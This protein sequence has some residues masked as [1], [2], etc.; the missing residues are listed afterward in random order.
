MRFPTG[1]WTG[2]WQGDLERTAARRRAVI[3]GFVAALHDTLDALGRLAA[4]GRDG[5]G[6]GYRYEGPR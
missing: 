2:D 5:Y 1:G 6:A 4:V 3:T